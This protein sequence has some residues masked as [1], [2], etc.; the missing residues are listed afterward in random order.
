MLVLD[1]DLG[2]FACASRPVLR[3]GSRW[4]RTRCRAL[5]HMCGR[6]IIFRFSIAVDG[7]TTSKAPVVSAFQLVATSDVKNT[8]DPMVK[9]GDL[10]IRN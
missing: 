2:L 9:M 5:D 1:A 4:R 3:G 8:V 7:P 6:C 10:A